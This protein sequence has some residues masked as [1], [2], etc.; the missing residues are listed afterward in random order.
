MGQAC[1]RHKSPHQVCSPC[2]RAHFG[3]IA[4]RT[5][6]IAKRLGCLRCLAHAAGCGH[7]Y[8]AS[9]SRRTFD[10]ASE[11][12]VSKKLAIVSPETQLP[13]VSVTTRVF[14]PAGRIL[15]SGVTKKSTKHLF[16]V[17][18][19]VLS[20]IVISA[21][22]VWPL[23]KNFFSRNSNMRIREKTQGIIFVS[24]TFWAAR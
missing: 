24:L 22:M 6:V 13:L 19:V 4:T 20:T 17:I 1:H 12:H 3:P 2:S 5:C 14:R 16:H 18:A 10:P 21:A 11:N 9:T 23:R 15:H 8:S 7:F